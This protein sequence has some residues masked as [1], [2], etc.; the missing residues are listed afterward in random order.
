MMRIRVF[1]CAILLVAC[2]SEQQPID[3]IDQV[4]ACIDEL[5]KHTSQN[6]EEGHLTALW[7]FARTRHFTESDLTLVV[8][9]ESLPSGPP[10]FD[11]IDDRI[12]ILCSVNRQM[13]VVG[14]KSPEVEGGRELIKE[15]VADG[16]A[17]E[18]KAFNQIAESLRS[19]TDVYAFDSFY[20]IN[21]ASIAMIGETTKTKISP[22]DFRDN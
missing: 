6:T 22:S 4:R 3:T 21:R 9:K 13:R 19:G 5:A 2:D 15:Y 7:T 17:A 8:F 16:E 10:D 14:L 12:G 1:L 20:R 11:K 18:D